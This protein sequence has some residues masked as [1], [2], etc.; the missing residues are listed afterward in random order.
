MYNKVLD[1][2]KV[3]AQTGSF[4]KASEKLFMS[5]TAIIK[6]MN[7]LE[8]RLGVKLFNRTY[9]GV[10]LTESGKI[11]Y[12][13]TLRIMKIS[14][15]MIE[16]VQNVPRIIRLGTS[17]IYPCQSF[18]KS[19]DT[20][21]NFQLEIVNIENDANHLSQLSKK[22]D[23]L[24]GPHNEVSQKQNI[25][26]IP[27]GNYSFYISMPKEHPLVNKEK[28]H[29]SD[30]EGYSLMI[31]KEGTS[32]INDLIR[33]E[34]IMKYPSIHLIDTIPQ[35]SFST[36]NTCAQTQNLLL[37]LECWKDIHPSLVSIPFDENFQM[38]YGIIFK[39]ESLYPLLK[40]SVI[41]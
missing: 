17:N 3:V 1:I 11:L 2:F 31:M 26:F 24:I 34:I 14:E 27:L 30:L 41:K 12:E 32:P 10:T 5:H 13:D 8:N 22:Y 9:H 33:K 39:D 19:F 6:Q 35:Y 16:H 20:H 25:H 15:E 29:F 36:F 7:L 40:Y 23:F 28:L 37:S 4:S 38:P 18:M 21:S